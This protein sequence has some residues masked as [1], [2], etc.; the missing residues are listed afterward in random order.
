MSE[1]EIATF[2]TAM[3]EIKAGQFILIEPV[4]DN[5]IWRPNPANPET[6]MAQKDWQ[7]AVALN[8]AKIGERVKCIVRGGISN[9]PALESK[10]E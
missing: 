10:S 2:G 7:Q 6:F 8:D 9:L 3:E 1:T 4:E 5:R